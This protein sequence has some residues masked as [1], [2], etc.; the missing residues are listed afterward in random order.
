[1]PH[2]DAHPHAH[3]RFDDIDRWV[4]R[5]DAPDRDGWQKPDVVIAALELTSSSIVA[6][7]GAG[8]G[9]FTV[10]IAPHVPDGGVLAVDV[11][12][13][14]L[15]HIEQR[16]LEAHLTNVD[17]VLAAPDDARLPMPVDVVLVVDTYHHIDAR[18]TYFARLRD[19]LR[20]GGRIVIVDFTMGDH[21]VGPPDDMK[22]P[23]DDVVVEM[24]NAGLTLSGRDETS[25]PYQ[26]IL[27]FTAS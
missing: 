13:N 16:A 12:P 11:E 4:A 26:Y 25:L 6:D 3:H 17:V 20:E 27:T 19:R 7:L 18:E 14:M 22:I 9:Y 1:M 2:D 10:R 5:F 24:N 8:T 15:H 23:P 21:P